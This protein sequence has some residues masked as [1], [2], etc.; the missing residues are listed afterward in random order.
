MTNELINGNLPAVEFKNLL[1]KAL[2]QASDVYRNSI[3]TVEREG[4]KTDSDICDPAAYSISVENNETLIVDGPAG[5]IIIVAYPR[6]GAIRF[7]SK[8]RVTNAVSY[9]DLIQLVNKI[10]LQ[11]LGIRACVPTQIKGIVFDYTLY[12]WGGVTPASIVV[13]LQE[14]DRL[15]QE[16][17]RD[18]SGVF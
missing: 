10:N 3:E 4:R 7:V 17:V 13:S 8:Y 9:A 18:N 12:L 5:T 6:Q 14:F 16:V 11:T 2:R 1:D 15:V